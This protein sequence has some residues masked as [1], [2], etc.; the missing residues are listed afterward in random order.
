MRTVLASLAALALAACHG[1]GDGHDHDHGD[2]DAH[3]FCQ[4]DEE[5]ATAGMAKLG[6]QG[7]YQVRIDSFTPDPLLVG[8]NSFNITILDA[9][10]D[11]VDGATLDLAETWQRVH[12]HGTPIEVSIT[13][14]A[15]P[16]ELTIDQMNVV[17]T[18]S[19]LFRF[20]PASGGTSDFVEFNFGIECPPDPA[21]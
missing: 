12:D 10:G 18:G 15:N 3:L 16:G 9:N 1:H 14:G 21:P 11:P 20:A 2:E 4:G 6:T 7:S 5:T 8:D 19:W 17:H 13:E